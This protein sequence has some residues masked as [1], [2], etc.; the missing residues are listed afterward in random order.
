MTVSRLSGFHDTLV[1]TILGNDA[2]AVIMQEII[3]LAS[4]VMPK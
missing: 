2:Y 4:Q 3:N 1:V